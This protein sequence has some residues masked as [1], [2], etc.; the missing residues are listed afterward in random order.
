MTSHGIVRHRHQET[1]SILPDDTQGREILRKL[2]ESMNAVR[3]KIEQDVQ[4]EDRV[5][6]RSSQRPAGGCTKLN[7][8][9]R[10]QLGRQHISS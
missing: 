7:E 9:R 10:P 8:L 2:F 1:A 6:E 5:H 4:H 3:K